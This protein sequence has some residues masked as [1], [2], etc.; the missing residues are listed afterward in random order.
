[1]ECIIKGDILVDTEFLARTLNVST[2]NL[3]HWINDGM[4]LHSKDKKNL[5]NLTEC[6]DWRS[7][8]LINKAIG[9]RL[10]P[11]QESAKKTRVQRQILEL[12]LKV[13]EG[14]L[15]PID[16]VEKTFAD[17]VTAIK[18]KLLNIP[19]AISQLFDSIVTADNLREIVEEQLRNALEDLAKQGIDES[20]KP[21]TGTT[22]S[23]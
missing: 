14:S 19:S 8:M 15:I 5:F 18:M 13:K 9:P 12:D 22:P 3:S 4:P 21:N 16:D 7:K 20:H 11:S 17:I 6:V 23:T 1:M 10:D 2:A